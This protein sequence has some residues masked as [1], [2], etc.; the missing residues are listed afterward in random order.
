LILLLTFGIILENGS[1]DEKNIFATTPIM[2]HHVNS[3]PKIAAPVNPSPPISTAI[4]QKILMGKG[5]GIN[6]FDSGL[7]PDAARP[8]PLKI[9]FFKFQMIRS[10]RYKNR[11]IFQ[12]I[13]RKVSGGAIALGP[14]KGGKKLPRN[15]VSDPLSAP[16]AEPQC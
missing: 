15:R 8:K 12:F 11:A 5:S 3:L 13:K 10:L 6:G 16:E 4:F 7:A 9:R 1:G 2:K 14:E